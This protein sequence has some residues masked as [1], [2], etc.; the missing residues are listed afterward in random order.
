M[1][2]I[3]ERLRSKLLI[4]LDSQFVP[5]TDEELQE[6]IDEIE[7]LRSLWRPMASAPRDGTQILGARFDQIKIVGSIMHW[8]RLSEAWFS[9]A[10]GDYLR[11]THWMPLPPAPVMA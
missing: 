4:L 5:I 10:T 8:S 6:A 7:R 3:V 11:P 2:D 9:L 1:T